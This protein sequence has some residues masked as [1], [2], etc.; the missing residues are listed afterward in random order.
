LTRIGWEQK[1]G[2]ARNIILKH[3]QITT[4]AAEV[5]PLGPGGQCNTN[6]LVELKIDAIQICSNTAC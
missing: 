1:L 2:S 4:I 5:S 6:T 3:G